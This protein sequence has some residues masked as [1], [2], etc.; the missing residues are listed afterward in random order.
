MEK[1]NLE[2]QTADREE[3]RFVPTYEDFFPRTELPQT[4]EV[5]AD[6]N[7]QQSFAP[8]LK[9]I[10][11]LNEGPLDTPAESP[12]SPSFQLSELSSPPLTSDRPNIIIH[13]PD[14]KNL[15]I[16]EESEHRQT[17]KLLEEAN[18]E[19]LDQVALNQRLLEKLHKPAEQSRSPVIEI[20]QPLIVLPLH[21]EEAVINF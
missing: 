16:Q 18:K 9:A 13:Q 8:K 2:E 10:E 17:R 15:L 19:Y 5:P 7:F 14:V 12:R 4:E 21:T 11:K 20:F 1:Q 3:P 6:F